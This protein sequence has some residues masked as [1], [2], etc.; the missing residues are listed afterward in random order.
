MAQHQY[1]PDGNEHSGSQDAN[2]Q[3]NGNGRFEA[4]VLLGCGCVFVDVL[5]HVPQSFPVRL[6]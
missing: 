5:A 6:E 4:L 3:Q 1:T 2:A